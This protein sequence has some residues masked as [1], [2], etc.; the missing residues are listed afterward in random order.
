MSQQ[1]SDEQ[2]SA[3]LDGEL[4]GDE[5]AAVEQHL[6]ENAD[7]QRLVEEL[8]ALSQA[9]QALPV[10]R[11]DADFSQRV[12]RRAERELLSP[13]AS[14]GAAAEKQPVDRTANTIPFPASGPSQPAAGAPPAGPLA[15]TQVP[16]RRWRMQV[17]PMLASAAALLLMAWYGLTLP[18]GLP[19][20]LHQPDE[21]QKPEDAR[22]SAGWSLAENARTDPAGS[23]KAGST[24]DSTARMSADAAPPAESHLAQGSADKQSAAGP[25]RL[26]DAR[27]PSGPEV[28]EKMRAGGAPLASRHARTLPE[29]EVQEAATSDDLV[30]NRLAM[31]KQSASLA[32]AA[33]APA[34][35][36]G[37]ASTEMSKDRRESAAALRLE[38]GPVS[39]VLTLQAP[40][41]RQAQADLLARFDRQEIAFRG[42]VDAQGLTALQA[43]RGFLKDASAVHRYRQMN[44]APGDVEKAKVESGPSDMAAQAMRKRADL[45]AAKAAGE[46]GAKPAIGNVAA[47]PDAKG[48]AVAPADAGPAAADRHADSANPAGDPPSEWQVVVLELT[49]EQAA[50]LQAEFAARD[51]LPP[52]SPA[53]KESAASPV[54]DQV[55]AVSPA[56]SPAG[57]PAPATLVR[58]K[59]PAVRRHVLTAPGMQAQQAPGEPRGFAPP[60]A[61]QSGADKPAIAAPAIAAADTADADAGV[62][63]APETASKPKADQNA[64]TVAGGA[65][66]FGGQNA[67]DRAEAKEVADDQSPVRESIA[68]AA[69]PAAP[70]ALAAAPESLPRDDAPVE[71]PAAPGA[72][73]GASADLQTAQNSPSGAPLGPQVRDF[74]AE[75]KPVPER[76]KLESLAA[77]SA[78][79]MASPLEHNA[80][81]STGPDR[82]KSPARVRV[83]LI[84]P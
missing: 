59:T 70:Q 14:N 84:L 30:A 32:D 24:A 18:R 22:E 25:S 39:A 80:G 23:F 36:A 29:S 11:L 67:T 48:L 9:V 51:G 40:R 34:A 19:V 33:P 77:S 15:A 2:L 17:W 7:A 45:Q 47:K 4:Q 41:N 55:A 6:R 31:K 20:A 10:Q 71:S 1:F 56:V 54:E 57:P 83:I 68:P 38:E 35:S 82:D 58:P 49:P 50:S 53:E 44:A 74:K 8:R 12:L 27:N 72:A 37:F 69:D 26:A 52:P 66:A 28:A 73:P 42:P 5:L 78:L 75:E 21:V 64:N 79:R 61:L 46:A 13:A 63:S 3:Y 81:Q 60:A 43:G 16:A 62:A 76:D 65:R